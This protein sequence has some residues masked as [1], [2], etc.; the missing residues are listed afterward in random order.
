LLQSCVLV[1]SSVGRQTLGGPG[2]RGT[3]SWLDDTEKNFGADLASL[4]KMQEISS[5][6]SQE[7]YYKSSAVVEIGDRLIT[8]DMSQK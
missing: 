3:D 5:V 4:F 2:T 6:D 8:I 7:N 1:T